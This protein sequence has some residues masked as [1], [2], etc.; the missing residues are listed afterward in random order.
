MNVIC[1]RFTDELDRGQGVAP[2]RQSVA[3]SNPDYTL[4]YRGFTY[5]I[6]RLRCRY[7][8]LE[9]DLIHYSVVYRG[10]DYRVN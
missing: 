8:S 1:R 6:N 10:S 9:A 5:E 3:D 4:L 2:L 7:R